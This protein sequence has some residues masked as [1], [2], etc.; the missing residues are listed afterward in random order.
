M[1]VAQYV[2][3]KGTIIQSKGLDPDL[4]ISIL[5]PYVN[6]VLGPKITKPDLNLIDFDEAKKKIDI[7]TSESI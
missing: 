3:P 6:I 2:T 5:N 4:P 1:T 7:C